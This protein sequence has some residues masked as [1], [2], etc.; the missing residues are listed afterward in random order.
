MAHVLGSPRFANGRAAR[1]VHTKHGKS[2]ARNCAA[3][4]PRYI[5]AS[6]S[7]ELYH[8]DQGKETDPIL[9]TFAMYVATYR[10]SRDT[11]STS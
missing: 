1:T 2:V 5:G 10:T 3:S 9:N 4:V 8:T 7:M 11:S 6:S